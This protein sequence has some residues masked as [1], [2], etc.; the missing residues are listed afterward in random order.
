ML[1]TELRSWP[2]VTVRP[3]FGLNALYRGRKI[4]AVLPR[5]RA[6]DAPDSIAFRLAHRRASVVER[7]REDKRIICPHAQGKWISFIIESEADL[8]D[9][10]QW[11][12][13]AFRAAGK[14]D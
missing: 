6:M 8:H 9:V 7:L 1:E 5:T 3:M 2:N 13:L 12:E 10:L 4:F 11:L 14:R